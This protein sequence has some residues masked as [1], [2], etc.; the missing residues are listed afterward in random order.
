MS[1]I[2]QVKNIS[3]G[4]LKLAKDNKNKKEEILKLYYKNNLTQKE[5][6]EKLGITH[7]KNA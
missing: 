1:K 7:N 3:K 5:I 6:A 4:D 2:M